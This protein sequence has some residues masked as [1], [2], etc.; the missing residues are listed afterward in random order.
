MRILGICGSPRG[1]QSNTRR[2]VED[3]LQ[4]A[5]ASGAEVELVD[6]SELELAYCKA[7]GS[8]HI[9]GACPLGDAFEPVR[10]RML[11]CDGIV[12]GSPNYFNSITAQLKTALDRL[13]DCIHCQSFLDKYACSVATSGGAEYDLATEYMNG[14]LMRLGCWVVGSA[15]GSVAIPGSF[16]AARK[17][18]AE[19]GAE[20]VQAIREHRTYPQQESVHAEMHERF[21]R[22][23][24]FNKDN[25]PHEYDYWKSKGWL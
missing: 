17:N 4:G 19:L 9:S 18:A 5:K 14:V 16:D 15:G 21:K 1:R 6:L 22:L 10:A 24:Q 7:C 8:C 25:W 11:L 3:V 23:I 2:L 12:L 13:S 20:L